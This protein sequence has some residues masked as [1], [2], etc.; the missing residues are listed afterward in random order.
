[1][2]ATEART[3]VTL[4][5][6]LY[7]TDFSPIAE[8]AAP[9]A[10][11]LARSYGSKIHAVHVRSLQAYGMAP[12]ESWPALKE[13][14]EFQMKEQVTHL[15]RLFRG[16]EHTATV[17]EGDV[18]DVVAKLIE[19][20][21]I[22]LV[23]MG[24]HGREGLGKIFLGSVAEGMLRRAPCPVLTVGPHVQVDPERATEMKRILFPTDFSP[25]SQAAAPY[26]I[27]LAQENQAHF[28][29]LH[30]L[31]RPRTGE[32]VLPQDLTAGT[33]EHMRALLPPEA[34][35]W[36]EP[37]FMVEV[38]EPTEAV[39][40]VAKQHNADV[41]VLGVKHVEGAFSPATHLPWATAHKVISGAHCPVLTVRG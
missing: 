19:E 8:S 7:A 22:D 6:I 29:M 13:A 5:N 28:D 18:W 37:N 31:A 20:K 26:A 1:M 27:S 3:R 4:K 34:E 25:A 10:A 15:D 23:V 35:L 16:V 41:I 32:L 40:R 21:R 2:K 17:S 38:G 39:L 12:P 9:Y 11:A 36:C 24:T 14:T 30:V 33:I